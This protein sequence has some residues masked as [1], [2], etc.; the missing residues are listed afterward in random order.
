MKT[1][2]VTLPTIATV[3]RPE[4]GISNIEYSIFITNMQAHLGNRFYSVSQNVL[5]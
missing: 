5:L 1:E 4:V 3:V 2:G